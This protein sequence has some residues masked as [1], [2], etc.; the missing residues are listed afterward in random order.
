MV[1]DGKDT[2]DTASSK[3]MDSVKTQVQKLWDDLA[4]KWNQISLQNKKILLGIGLIAAGLSLL[5]L[6]IWL[7]QKIKRHH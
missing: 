7:I 5:G 2:K 4:E 1:I 6:A 3:F